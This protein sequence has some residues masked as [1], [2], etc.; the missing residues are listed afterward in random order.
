[1]RRVKYLKITHAET[2]GL[3][4]PGYVWPGAVYSAYSSEPCT[5]MKD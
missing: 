2:F 1:M 5:Q 3:P 4:V